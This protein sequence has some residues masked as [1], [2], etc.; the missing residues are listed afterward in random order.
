M[1]KFPSLYAF[2]LVMT[3]LYVLLGLFVMFSPVMASF[4]PGWKHWV[5]GFLMIVYAGVRYKRL[6]LLK[7]NI[8]NDAHA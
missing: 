2:T 4:L 6:R 1:A 5:L 3:A 7:Q 8:E